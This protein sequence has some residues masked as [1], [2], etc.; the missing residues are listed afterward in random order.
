MGKKREF[1]FNEYMYYCAMHS[2]ELNAFFTKLYEY[3]EQIDDHDSKIAID[4]FVLAGDNLFAKE[5]ACMEAFK[6]VDSLGVTL[7]EHKKKNAYQ[8]V[9]PAKGEG[10]AKNGKYDCTYTGHPTKF[11]G[12]E[13]DVSMFKSGVNPYLNDYLNWIE[14]NKGINL[15]TASITEQI[16][17]LEVKLSKALIGK[18]KI[19]REIAKLESEMNY[20]NEQLKEGEKLKTKKEVFEA[21][22][23]EQKEAIYNAL[24]C[25]NQ[26][27]EASKDLKATINEYNQIQIKYNAKRNRTGKW[28]RAYTKML[29]E[30]A[31]DERT[32]NIVNDLFAKVLKHREAKNYPNG[33]A[34]HAQSTE[35]NILFCAIDWYASLCMSKESQNKENAAKKAIK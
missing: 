15:K 27:M 5:F 28:E 2:Y 24:V 11:N 31:I 14:K 21:F 32:S 12:L 29:Y 6:K 23:Q 16:K 34:I 17:K 7:S 3:G 33:I 10:F 35:T 8:I 30:G 25:L 4:K 19:R 26:S 1:T 18:E 13:L 22:T 9:V 20:L